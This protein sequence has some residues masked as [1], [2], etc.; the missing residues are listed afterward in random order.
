L[1]IAIFSLLVLIRMFL[2]VTTV[3]GVSMMPTLMPGDRLLVLRHW[4]VRWLRVDQI[5]T[6]YAPLEASRPTN[7]RPRPE[8]LFIKRLIGLPGADVTINISEI[9]QGMRELCSAECD[10]DGYM[11]WHIPHGRCFVKGDATLSRDSVVWGPIPLHSLV[12]VVLLKLPRRA[13][14][15]DFESPIPGIESVTAKEKA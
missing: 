10:G 1:L 6:G 5:V 7:G 14:P 4:P 13:N 15:V 12:A 11:S 3:H 9:A 8:P 2:T